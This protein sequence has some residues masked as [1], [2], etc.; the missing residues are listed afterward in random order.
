MHKGLEW[1]WS[2]TREPILSFP[3]NSSGLGIN[4][5]AMPAI[6]NFNRCTGR[7]CC[8]PCNRSFPHRGAL[9]QHLTTA[10]AHSYCMRCERDF[11]SDSS[12]LQHWIGSPEHFYCQDCEGHFDDQWDLENHG[13]EGQFECENCSIFF[14]T[15]DELEEH[16]A[17]EHFYCIPCDRYFKNQNNLDTHT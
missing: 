15:Q 9:D 16:N 12:R 10:N 8:I 14:W 1:R 13:C 2:S 5:L 3:S 6:F 11:V 7:W 4:Y 17:A